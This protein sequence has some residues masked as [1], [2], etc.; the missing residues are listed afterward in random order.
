MPTQPGVA[1]RRLALL[2]ATSSYS[3]PTLQQLRAPGRDAG[4]LAEVLANPQIGG[5]TV[6]TLINASHGELLRQIED[7]CA[8]KRVNDQLLIYLS[9]HGVLDGHGRLYYATS[10]TQNDRAA[11]TAVAAAWLNERLEDCRA[12]SQIIILDCCYSGAFS[13]ESKGAVDL[14]L[15]DRF[16]PHGR[17]R[18]VMTASRSTEYSFERDHLAGSGVRSVFTKAIVDGLRTGD[19]DSD[20]DGVITVTNLYQFAYDRVRSIEPRQTPE[21]WTYGAEG[22]TVIAHSVRGRIIEPAA[23]PVDLRLTI[24]SPRPRVRETAV[25]ELAELLDTARPELV[26]GA[27][28]TLQKISSEDIPRVAMLARA[29]VAAPRGTASQA[30]SRLLAER[31]QVPLA[32]PSQFINGPTQDETLPAA[33]QPPSRKMGVQSIPSPPMQGAQG[34]HKIGRQYQASDIERALAAASY[35]VPI[36]AVAMLF[37]RN[38]F[39]RINAVQSLTIDAIGVFLPTF[40]IGPAYKSTASNNFAPAV[41]QPWFGLLITIAIIGLLLSVFLIVYCLVRVIQGKIPIIVGLSRIAGVQVHRTPTDSMESLDD[42]L[43]PQ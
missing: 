27:Y 32:A 8:D 4:D 30:V 37:R 7:F 22:D 31:S 23:L 6:Q 9:C 41:H 17:G 29:A 34:T 12:R 35:L 24:E 2:I 42:E 25:A 38:K 11:A 16:Q 1:A 15:Q 40:T 36:F 18:I 43:R 14:A 26:L 19:A 10:D 13:R 20:K 33:S 3:D 5:F 28:Q 39:L 21:L